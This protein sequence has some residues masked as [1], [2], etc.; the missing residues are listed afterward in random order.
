MKINP[1]GAWVIGSPDRHIVSSEL[2]DEII[3]IMRAKDLKNA[4]DLGCGNGLYVRQI[5]SAGFKCDGFDGNPLT[6]EMT[7][8]LASVLDLS[9]TIFIGKYD[10]VVSLE[11][12]EHI[13]SMYEDIFLNNLTKTADKYIVLSWAI[14]GQ[15][16]T[17]HVN[18]R[19]NDWVIDQMK[20]REFRLTDDFYR[21]RDAVVGRKFRHFKNTILT[22][23]KEKI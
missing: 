17:G 4:V 5:R 22:F 14:E 11:V 2:C 15:R 1:N 7:E 23:E 10:L 19:N 6:E 18:C 16:G 8:G 13:P 3:S 20:K 21:L 12:G 9:N